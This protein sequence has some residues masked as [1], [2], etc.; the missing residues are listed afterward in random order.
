[1]GPF[2]TRLSKAVRC[3]HVVR[4]RCGGAGRYPAAVI[5]ATSLGLL[6]L[7]ATAYGKGRTTVVAGYVS[8]G[9]PVNGASVSVYG[10]AGRRMRLREKRAGAR[11]DAQ[12]FFVL[13]LPGRPGLVRV[14]ASGGR[15]GGQ[16]V[17]GSLQAIIRHPG[18]ADDAFLNPVSTVIAAYAAAHPGVSLAHATGVGRRLLGLGAIDS[19]GRELLG[20]T[21]YFDGFSFLRVARANGGVQRYVTRL[22]RGGKAV[23]FPGP[24]APGGSGPGAF[25]PAG[26][27]P[28]G[29]RGSEPGAAPAGSFYGAGS[30]LSFEEV[31]A[32]L[33]TAGK[34]VGAVGKIAQAASF[35]YSI[36]QWATGTG[37]NT[38]ILKAV[39]EMQK[40]LRGIQESLNSIQA[41]LAIG[42]NEILKQ[43]G[44]VAF[45]QQVRPLKDLAGTVAATEDDFQD[46]LNNKLSG[47]FSETL[48]KY[49]LDAINRNVTE[50]ERDF[51][52]ANDVFRDAFFKSTVGVGTTP[53]YFYAGQTLLDGT[54]H[55]MTPE[56]S[57]RL[58]EFASFVLEYQA[59]AFNLMVRW[60]TYLSPDAPD[61]TL[62][63]AM[64]VYL[65]F[66]TN[67]EATNWLEN[68]STRDLLGDG[69]LS[70]ELDLLD[71][72]S[73]VPRDA[74]VEADGLDNSQGPMWQSMNPKEIV[75]GRT[76]YDG[77]TA[78]GTPRGGMGCSNLDQPP[79]HVQGLKWANNP[80]SAI[81]YNNLSDPDKFPWCQYMEVGWTA[82]QNDLNEAVSQLSKDARRGVPFVGWTPAS[83]TEA[84]ALFTRLK[85][86]APD[87]LRDVIDVKADYWDPDPQHT[88]LRISS[89]DLNQGGLYHP[90]GGYYY[91]WVDGLDVTTLKG[92]PGT[93][94]PT[95]SEIAAMG[96]KGS[97]WFGVGFTAPAGK[98]N[99]GSN[100]PALHVLFRRQPDRSEQYWPTG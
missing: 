37:E 63:N 50:I 82:A 28:G 27:Q 41:S 13:V 33:G 62:S 47:N 2:G 90:A 46:I 61:R 88:S 48:V 87:R 40:D 54:W 71:T 43:I 73:E 59:L 17:K 66:D 75:L 89:Y 26:S 34:A 20:V 91:D 9:A 96:T 42:F 5:L 35:A 31:K 52:Q 19:I 12:G 15:A 74:I 57:K 69:D 49:K 94:P 53:A 16:R 81:K 11:S 60:E 86:I 24:A 3:L 97:C 83:L 14:V 6:G 56:D 64:K 78:D 1:M 4:R 72:I 10:P 70:Q 30:Q 8:A 44:Q 39:Q 93:T 79:Y 92:L 58:R 36:Y 99:R 100:C 65:G 55:F 18:L 67:E 21:P 29:S 95:A 45:N 84:Q 98:T 80:Y 38:L 51:Q 23:F 25:A 22:I 76:I 85:S 68:G 77:P 7:A 32:L